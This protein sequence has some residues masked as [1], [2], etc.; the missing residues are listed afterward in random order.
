MTQAANLG[1]LGTNVNTSGKTSLT[2]GVTGVLP[3]ANMPSGSIIQV[4][5]TNWNTVLNFSAA[6]GTGQNLGGGWSVIPTNN[7]VNITTSIANSKLMV[8][9]DGNM[10]PYNPTGSNT[11]YS[12]W[13]GGWGFVADPAGGTTWSRVGSGQNTG[14]PNNVKFFSSRA[15]TYQGIAGTDAYWIATCNGNYLYSPAVASGT[16]VRLAI[17]YFHYSASPAHG[18]L[19]INAN[20]AGSGGLSSGGDAY[21]GG[22]ATTL[23]VFE[24]AP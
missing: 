2:T 14:Y 20:A 12:D 7:Y 22:F 24:V 16:T 10:A 23:T 18:N 21:N 8:M 11:N 1:A 17:E 5:S 4:Q 6:N 9:F 3:K 13:I 15:T 19:L